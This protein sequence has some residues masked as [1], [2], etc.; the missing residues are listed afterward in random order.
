VEFE[1]FS[2]IVSLPGK[3]E[4]IRGYSGVDLLIID[5]AAR[6]KDE[7]NASVRP[8][9]AVSGGRVVALTTPFGKRG[10][11]HEGWISKRPWL[12][13][14]VTADQCPRISEEFLRD[15]LEDLG[16]YWYS[17]EDMCE[18]L[19][20][21]DQFFDTDAVLSAMVRGRTF[22]SEEQQQLPGMTDGEAFL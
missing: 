16:D 3:E 7:L 5:E 1:N 15:E 18:F 13:I 17:Q 9:L 2:R 14:M 22:L 6:V 4:T 11:F 19:D 10:W 20:T 8:M 21:I 12:R